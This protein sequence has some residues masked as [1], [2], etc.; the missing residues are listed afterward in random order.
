MWTTTFSGGKPVTLAAVAWTRLS[1]CEPVHTSQPSFRTWTVQ[2]TGSMVACARN[3]AWY[4][5]STFCAAGGSA[6]AGIALLPGDHARLP[7]G[8]V[9]LPD[10][11]LGA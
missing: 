1:T 11:V 6:V 5:A 9:Q 8:R 7:R 4:T 10:H 3:G 2:F